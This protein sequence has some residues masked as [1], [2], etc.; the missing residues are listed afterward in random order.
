MPKGRRDLFPS[1]RAK[2]RDLAHHALEREDL[3]MPNTPDTVRERIARTNR[4]LLTLVSDLS[5]SDFARSFGPR[6]PAIRFHAWHVSRWS[7]NV[8]SWLPRLTP[9]LRRRLGDRPELW[10]RDG[11]AKAWGLSA[12]ELGGDRTGMGLAD[13]AAAALPLPSKDVMLAYASQ[14]FAALEDALKSIDSP[15]F[16]APCK[17]WAGRDTTVGGAVIHHL[18]HINRHLG[19]V[20]ALRGI[21][22]ARGT[23]TA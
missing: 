13:A 8:Q 7:D 11:L 19:M 6:A 12:R 5:E 1:S 17:D 23:A 14:T 22:G 20:E 4:Q 9:E 21:L 15:Q 18:I 10:D 16:E 3:L 2:S